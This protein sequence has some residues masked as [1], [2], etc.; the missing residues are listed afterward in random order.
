MEKSIAH[1]KWRY[2][3]KEFDPGRLLP[4]EKIDGIKQA[5]NLTATSYGL[6]PIKMVVLQNKGIQKKLVP[7]SYGQ[8]Q[9]ENASHVLVIC[10]E[11]S[12]NAEYIN[13]Y[14]NLVKEVRGTNDTVLKPFRGFLV[15][16][17]EKKKPG[18]IRI[19]A[20]NQAYLALG[21]LLSYCALE[22]IDSCPMEGFLPGDY[23]RILGLGKLGLAPVLVLPIG[24]RS[25]NDPFSKMKKV[26]KNV[27]E[28][29]IEIFD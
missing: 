7:C 14:F 24:Y 6:Q 3:V 28:S 29:V 5:F 22:E 19:W 16:D 25:G 17:F 23:D 26:R 12:I 20:T 27:A 4:K 9:V 18:D 2:A 15:Q 10:I 13:Q 1:L 21:N 11:K 8:R